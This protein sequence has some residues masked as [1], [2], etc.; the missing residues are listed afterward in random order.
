MKLKTILK[1]E[2]YK[3][4]TELQLRDYTLMNRAAN[5]ETLIDPGTGTII[6]P[7]LRELRN[8]SRLQM[9]YDSSNVINPE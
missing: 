3:G 8:N 2:N 5:S 6:G 1:T 9:N 4:D 7:P